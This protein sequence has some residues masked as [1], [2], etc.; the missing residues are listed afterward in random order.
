MKDRE[1][2]RERDIDTDIYPESNKNGFKKTETI[3]NTNHKKAGGEA[4]HKPN[5]TNADQI[6]DDTHA[7]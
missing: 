5:L 4:N 7:Q 6:A 1:Q 3:Q 2:E